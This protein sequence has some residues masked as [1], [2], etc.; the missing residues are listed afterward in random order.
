MYPPHA[1]SI[2]LTLSHLHKIIT[3][4][5][6]ITGLDL[7]QVSAQASVDTTAPDI[8]MNTPK[9]ISAQSGSECVCVRVCLEGGSN[10]RAN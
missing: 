10:H 1:F 4:L 5:I 3:P 6:Q 7:A 9:L 2:T 8:Q